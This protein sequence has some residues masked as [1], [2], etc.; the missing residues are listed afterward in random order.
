MAI[1]QGISQTI[2]TVPSARTTQGMVMNSYTT[3]LGRVFANMDSAGQKLIEGR[4]FLTASEDPGGAA[5]AY[6]LRREY[7]KNNDYLENTKSIL[8]T[9][10]SI[11]GNIDTISKMA[12]SAHLGLERARNGTWTAFDR[13]IFA[14]ELRTQARTAVQM[15]NSVFEAKFEFGGSDTKNNAPF[16]LDESVNP[17]IL[18]YRGIDVT[19]TDPADRAQLEAWANEKIYVDMGFGLKV[20]LLDASGNPDP[21]GT[22]VVKDSTAFNISIPGINLLGNYANASTDPNFNF[23][24]EDNLILNI[25]KIADALEEGY[26][27]EVDPPLDYDYTAYLWKKLDA[28]REHILVTWTRLGAD[29]QFLETRRGVLERNSDNLNSKILNVEFDDM[30]V[31]IGNYKMAD[32]VYRAALEMGTRILTPS[33]IDFMR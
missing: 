29:Y 4:K 1:S 12:E 22:P 24:A 18:F 21:N 15:L 6:Q 27:G 17:P 30:E 2:R 19:S 16:R 11:D 31:A 28:Q 9:M 20:E 32:Y 26:P 3:R 7:Q 8:D 14:N 10:D 23:Q 13:T 25:F 33:F 5:R